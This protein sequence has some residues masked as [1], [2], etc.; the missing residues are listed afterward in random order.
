MKKKAAATPT[1]TPPE[2]KVSSA[3]KGKTLPE[4][5][6]SL[7][8][9]EK[10]PP[11]R[12]TSSANKE[13]KPKA[14]WKRRLKRWRKWIILAILIVAAVV[15]AKHFLRTA[16][17]S[18]N[19]ESMY[20]EEPVSRS[21]ITSSLSS[22]GTLQPANSYTVTTLKEGEILSDTFEEGDV[23]EKDTTLYQIDSSD[24]ESNLEKS[25]ISL[26]Q[27]QRSYADAVDDQN[28]KATIAGSIFSLDVELGDEVKQGQ[29]I[30]IIR[31]SN[32]MTLVVPFPAD[33][34][35]T[36]YVG[37]PATV[38]LDGSFETLTGSVQSVSGSDIVGTG[39]SI[40]RDV[41]IAVQ[42]PGGLGI[43]QSATASINGLNCAG[44]STFTYAA[45]STVTSEVE[46]TVTAINVNEGSFV[47]KDQVIVQVGGKS[48]NDKIQ[49]AEDSLRNA[50]LSME[51]SQDQ[52]DDYTIKSPISGTIVDKQYKTGD[53][54]ESGKALCT[55]YDLSYLEM[56]MSIDELDINKAAVG[57]TVE[58]TADAVEGKTYSGVITK[59]SVAGTTSNGATSYPV[60]VRID[61]M[62][63]LLPGMNVDA[64]IVLEQ[65]VDTLCVPNTA[66]SRGDVVLV[67]QD[68]PSAA[69]A[70]EQEAPEGYVYV[71]VETGISDDNN[72][73]ILSGLQD[74]D[75][76]AYVARESNDNSMPMM[77]GMG[78]GPGGGGGM[79]GAPGGGGGGMGGGPGGGGGGG[80]MP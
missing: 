71:N 28:I 5:Q 77:G 25:Q 70:I 12:Q 75:T 76:I 29:E 17:S 35:M 33:D 41:K 26:N 6:T 21:T 56:D 58:I 72:T 79:G 73:Q 3:D 13:K 46:G 49:N 14:L 38:T 53:T 9:A 4:G 78:G 20:T 24:L 19:T 64:E 63:E 67:T 34:A 47:A 68:S 61:D 8:N 54:I 50:E 16:R 55:I 44:S 45:E 57:Q 36:F 18:S 39:N 48:L 22:S 59:V 80:P 7:V 60:T 66:V 69:N 74:G 62:G 43:E 65:A 1:E 10:K 37:Q 40:M 23:V 2:G 30:A 52:L 51:S 27:A 15:A 42:N 11:E 32:L 31:E